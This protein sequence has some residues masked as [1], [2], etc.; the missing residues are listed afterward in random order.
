MALKEYR[1]SFD[2]YGIDFKIKANNK[3]EAK[4]KALEKLNKLNLKKFI[5]KNCSYI[6][7]E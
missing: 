1:A 3:P 5:N 4:R 7:K 2:L 6:E